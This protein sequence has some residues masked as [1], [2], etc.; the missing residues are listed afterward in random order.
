MRGAAD[1]DEIDANTRGE[2][3]NSARI[4]SWIATLGP[5]GYLP[6]PGTCGTLVAAILYWW[7]H[8]VAWLQGV[9]GGR[10]LVALVVGLA[11]L[12]VTY[13]LPRF[14]EHDPQEI[15]IDEV[16]GF[17][18]TMVG[19]APTPLVLALAFGYFRVIDILKPLGIDRIEALP[20]AWGVIGDD[21][22]AGVFAN[23]LLYATLYFLRVLA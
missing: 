22:V 20:G 4:A 21:V 23:I 16:A 12:V 6:A 19:F 15:V 13:A 1:G 17:F 8:H 14:I 10:L 11:Y 18:V 3:V 5:V 2:D 7:L 9:V